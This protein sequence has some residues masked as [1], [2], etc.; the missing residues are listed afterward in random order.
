[1][2]ESDIAKAT[3]RSIKKN[4]PMGAI[5][6]K[7]SDNPITLHSVSDDLFARIWSVIAETMCVTTELSRT[8]KEEVATLVSERN[9][10]P[11]CITAHTMMSVVS[12][13][14]D[15]QDSK[16]KNS[17]EDDRKTKQHEQALQY[18]EMLLDEMS[19]SASGNNDAIPK[20]SGHSVGS[21][22]SLSTGSKKSRKG[23]KRKFSHLSA[24]AKAEVAL[25]V[26][27]GLRTY[28]VQPFRI[29]TGSMQPTLNGIQVIRA[30]DDFEKPWLGKQAW[31][32]LTKGRTY[33]SYVAEGDMQVVRG[34]AGHLGRSGSWL[35]W[36]TRTKFQFSD[37]TSIKVPAEY[38]EA[39]KIFQQEG[40]YELKL[41]K[42]RREGSIATVASF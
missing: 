29:P 26:A 42:V 8:T 25:V 40:G 16:D 41:G 11:V 36:L 38:N 18:A 9:T 30:S 23:K 34:P 28:V 33:K 32:F 7:G 12:M 39:T 19:R 21:G 35:P 14:V 22:G 4:F 2:A 5:M 13:V 15:T 24:S 10:C 27:L 17:A 20:G 6:A 3:R 31:E 37:G 1:M